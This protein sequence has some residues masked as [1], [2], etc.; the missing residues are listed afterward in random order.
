[1]SYLLLFLFFLNFPNQDASNTSNRDIPAIDSSIFGYWV[2]V[3][4]ETNV[5]KSI[6]KIYMENGIAKGEI[7]EL[8]PGATMTHCTTC[9]GE[10]QNR[11][12]EGLVI[13][14]GFEFDGENWVNGVIFDPSKGKEY[15]SKIFFEKNSNR[16]TLSVRGYWSVIY[17][18]Q[19]WYKLR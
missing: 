10:D 7:V 9:V 14:D 18:T 19:T 12:L 15:R 17:R 13:L 2:T 16:N 4:D 8:L 6:V 11:S 3:D 5:E 1:M